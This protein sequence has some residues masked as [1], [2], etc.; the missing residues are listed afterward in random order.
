[1]YDAGKKEA[2]EKMKKSGEKRLSLG[3]LLLLLICGFILSVNCKVATVQ[4]ADKNI[5]P[6]K[7]GKTYTSYDF[8]GDGK[9][10]RFKYVTYRDGNEYAKIYIN[11]KYKNT[12]DL[13]RGGARS[14][15]G[16]GL[17]LCHVSRK[18]VFLVTENGAFAASVCVCYAY[19]NGKFR[20]IA[21]VQGFDYNGP[22]KVSGNTLYFESVAG[23]HSWIFANYSGPS[24]YI[25]YKASNKRLKLISRYANVSGT[26]TATKSFKTSSKPTSMNSSGVMVKQGD[27]V[28]LQSVY[29]SPSK[30][31]MLKISVNGKAGWIPDSGHGYKNVNLSGALTPVKSYGGTK[32]TFTVSCGGTGSRDF[33]INV[34]CSNGGNPT[35]KS[36]NESVATVNSNGVVTARKNGQAT[37]TAS[38]RYNNETY[39][40]SRKITVKSREEY[41]SWSGWSLN[42]AYN[43]SYQQVRTT[44]LYRYY[45]FLCPVCGG[46]EP[47]QGMSDCHKYK[48]TLNNGVTAWFTTPYSAANSAPYSYASYKRYTFSLGDGKRWNFS[49]GNIND[50]AVGT[51]DTD[52]A[53]VVIR[54]GYSTRSIRTGYYVSSVS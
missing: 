36:S 20:K 29:F 48:L 54:T 21:T 47:L 5:I 10:D 27:Q 15:D 26:Y 8:T 31:T 16:D 28:K 12:L 37:I 45:C 35:W 3:I 38:V 9:K 11:G 42:P 13:V 41:G 49:T 19:E 22:V 24:C 43:N 52:S 39:S 44:P 34:K 25:K 50:H 30:G 17:Y 7:S 53:A 6:L 33:I 18:N 1:M 2:E 4:A 14:A 40:V 51:K 46:R 32:P 23:K